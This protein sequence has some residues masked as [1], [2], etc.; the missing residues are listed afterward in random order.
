MKRLSCVQ[1][2]SPLL[3]DRFASHCLRWLAGS[4]AR[5]GRAAAQTLGI[6]AEAEGPGFGRRTAGIL[7]QLLA[8]L[9]AD[10]SQA[11]NVLR[12]LHRRNHGFS[13]S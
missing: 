2:A 11:S 6:L 3:R 4:D 5:L 9:R 7:P 12:H 10:S 1:R 8:T 13:V